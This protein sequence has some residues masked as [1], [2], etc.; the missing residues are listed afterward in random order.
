[1]LPNLVVM[2]PI[3]PECA[4][5]EGRK[6]NIASRHATMREIADLTRQV[7][8]RCTIRAEKGRAKMWCTRQD[9]NL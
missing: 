2:A 8:F 1:V 5:A 3:V 7:L 4:I 6:A 9:S